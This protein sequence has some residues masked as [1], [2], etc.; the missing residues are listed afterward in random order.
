[1]LLHKADPLLLEIRPVR[2]RGT[3]R[4][5]NSSETSLLKPTSFLAEE[6]QHRSRGSWPR[7]PFRLA[8][9]LE[10]TAGHSNVLDDALLRGDFGELQL[11]LVHHH[12]CFSPR[13]L[14][15]CPCLL[16]LGSTLRCC[17]LRCGS[18]LFALFLLCRSCR[19]G[20]AC[21]GQLGRQLA[22]LVHEALMASLQRLLNPLHGLRGVLV[23]LALELRSSQ[24]Q[25]LQQQIVGLLRQATLDNRNTHSAHGLLHRIHLGKAFLGLRLGRLCGS[26]TGVALGS[27]GGVG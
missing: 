24:G 14:E 19:L 2:S 18:P 22:L 6:S 17:L 15:R 5:G 25:Q 20:L 27:H 16:G 10:E 26:W 1:M 13:R 9:L 11:L 21:R 4:R 7:S 12:H 8:K 3:Q 23:T